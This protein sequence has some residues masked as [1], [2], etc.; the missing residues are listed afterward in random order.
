VAYGVSLSGSDWQ[1]IYIRNVKTGKDLPDRIP[2]VKFVTAAWTSDNKGF[3]YSRQ[4]TPGTVP[5][6]DE[7]YYPK[8]YHHEL[9][10]DPANDV[11]I[12]ER[13]EQKETIFEPKTTVDGRYLV[14]GIYKGSADNNEVFVMPLEDGSRQLRPMMTGFDALYRYVGSVGDDIFFHTNKDAPRGRIIAVNVNAPE[15]E[16]WKTLVPEDRDVISQAVVANRRLVVETMHNAHDRLRMYAL[17]GTFVRNVELPAIGSVRDLHGRPES[18]MLFF[19]FRSFVYPTTIYRYD[20]QAETLVEYRRPEIDFDREDYVTRQVW[21][22]SKDGTKVPMFLVHKRNLVLNGDNPTMI[23]G[24]GGFNVSM[25]P[26]FSSTRLFWLE[27]GGIYAVVTLRGGNEFGE[28]WHK[29]GMLENKQNVFD[30]FM[31]SAEYLI[32]QGYTRPG[33]IVIDG[34][35]NGGL[36]TAACAVQRPD[37]YGVVLTRVPVADMLRYH[38]FTVARFWIPEYGSSED[39]EQFKFLYEYSPLQNVRPGVEYPSTLITTAD[40]DDRVDPGQAK[41]YA[42]AIQAANAS[43]KPMLIRIETRAGHGGGKPTTKR[44]KE[45]ADIFGFTLKEM[46]LRVVKRPE[47]QSQLVPGGQ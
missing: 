23:Y 22:E 43:D 6:G 35:S 16:S 5:A 1:E 36:L 18:D 2:H 37:L 12:Y 3:Y 20:F 29:A 32:E 25:T 10:D 40:T 14:L 9:G 47:A 42:A 4:P 15:P 7:H 39:P 30:D 45:W 38:L 41:K 27:Q 19:S 28:E 34:A 13:P 24:Y 21:F 31:G 8:I 33:R 11:F 44:I 46:N 26:H 17:D